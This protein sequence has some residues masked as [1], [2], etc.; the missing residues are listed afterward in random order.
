[1]TKLFCL[2]IQRQRMPVLHKEYQCQKLVFLNLLKTNCS[3]RRF[4][5][6]MGLV[7]GTINFSYSATLGPQTRCFIFRLQW[8]SSSFQRALLLWI[9][10]IEH[11][12][13]YCTFHMFSFLLHFYLELELLGCLVVLCLILQ[14]TEYLAK[15]WYHFTFPLAMNL[16]SC[17]FIS[18]I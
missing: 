6:N 4:S 11:A 9:V 10:Q 15:W 2:P 13:L 18:S 1:M 7:L 3:G 16:G 8:K 17:F 5:N 14:E 12:F